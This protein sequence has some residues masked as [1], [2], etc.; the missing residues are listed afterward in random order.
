M[1]KLLRYGLVSGLLLIGL[2]VIAGIALKVYFNEERLRSLVLPPL[3]EA[4]GRE[5]EIKSLQLDLLSGV[6]VVDLVVKEAD[7]TSDFVAVKEFSL[8]Y[9]LWPLLEKK[10]EISRIR[11]VH[12]VIKVWRNREGHYNYSKLKFLQ[13]GAE[14]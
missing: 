6:K 5:V 14:T 4:L 11:V 12:P 13:T 7:G 10:L 8:G 1:K 9:S 3:R 2:L